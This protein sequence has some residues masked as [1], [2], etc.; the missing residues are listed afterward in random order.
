MKKLQEFWEWF[1]STGAYLLVGLAVGWVMV[2]MFLAA[3]REANEPQN[4]YAQ[5]CESAGGIVVL[6]T[7]DFTLTCEF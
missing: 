4:R 7:Y 6:E 1:Y 5:L 2:M 3:A